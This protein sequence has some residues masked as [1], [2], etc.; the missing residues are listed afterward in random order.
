M[1]LMNICWKKVKI[2]EKGERQKDLS[3]TKLGSKNFR[4][5]LKEEQ[6]PAQHVQAK[7]LKRRIG[8]NRKCSWRCAALAKSDSEKARVEGTLAGGYV[9]TTDG[10]QAV[11]KRSIAGIGGSVSAHDSG[12]LKQ[13]QW[14]VQMAFIP[15]CRWIS[16]VKK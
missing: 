6:A 3:S 14:L 10:R 12:G 8:G 15:K 16:A 4:T 2:P 11:G 5:A 7:T 13:A 1:M 9:R